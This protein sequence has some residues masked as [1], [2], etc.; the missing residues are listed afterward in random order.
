MGVALNHIIVHAK[1]RWASARFL[2]GILGLA[3][4]PAWGPF[5]PVRTANGVTLDFADARDF[6]PQHCAFL[7]SEEEFDA[8]LA[9]IKAAGV[10]F[11]ASF[12]GTGRGEINRLYGGRGVYFDDPDGHLFELITQP[13]GA[14]PEG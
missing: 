2:A 9:R 5:V 10:G 4:G 13:Y 12:D 7:V 14:V 8:A 6:R 3:A 1:D 11:Y